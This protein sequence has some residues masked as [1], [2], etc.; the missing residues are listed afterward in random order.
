MVIQFLSEKLQAAIREFDLNFD[1]DTVLSA[2]EDR[3]TLLKRQPI[4]AELYMS[5]CSYD[6]FQSGE[7]WI[8]KC[9]L[10]SDVWSNVAIIHTEKRYGYASVFIDG[11]LFIIGGW[12]GRHSKDNMDD[13]NRVLVQRINV[14]TGEMKHLKPL[15]WPLRLM[16]AVSFNDEIYVSGGTDIFGIK[17]TAIK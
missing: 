12:R 7:I 10:D 3:P 6:Y 17:R 8:Q 16:Q 5:T 4:P 9:N 14:S 13:R 11:Q 15:P 2:R 1:N